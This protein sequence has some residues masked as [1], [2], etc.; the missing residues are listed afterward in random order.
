MDLPS[1]S[2]I[3]VRAYGELCKKNNNGNQT[4]IIIEEQLND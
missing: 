3:S 2:Q 4:N 1:S